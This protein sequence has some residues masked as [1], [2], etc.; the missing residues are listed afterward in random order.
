MKHVCKGLLLTLLVLVVALSLFACPK[1]DEP[2]PTPDPEPLP[3]ETVSI[4]FKNGDA[5]VATKTTEKNTALTAADIPAAPV[6]EGKTFLG[7]YIGDTKVEAGYIAA[8]D[9]TA[10]AKFEDTTYTLI[11]KNGDETVATITVKHGATPAEDALPSDPEKVGFSFDGWLAGDVAFDEEA[12]VTADATYT[13]AFTKTHYIVIFKNGDAET[14]VLVPLNAAALTAEMIP[15]VPAAP[16]GSGCDGWFADG[17][18]AESGLAIT[19]DTTF[20]AHFVGADA[21]AGVYADLVHGEFLTIT[22]ALAASGKA[23]GTAKLTPDGTLS[24]K[25]SGT[26]YTVSLTA[27][28]VTLTVNEYDAMEEEFVDTV[29]TMTRLSVVEGLAGTYKFARTTSYTV[30]E[31]GVVTAYDN[32]SS[33]PY[34]GLVTK[35]EDGTM[36]LLKKTSASGRLDALAITVDSKGNWVV[37]DNGYAKIYVKAEKDAEVKA[38]YCSA[39]GEYLYVIYL[40]KGSTDEKVVTYAKSAD[41]ISCYATIDGTIASNN[42]VTFTAGDK[43]ATVKLG[44]LSTSEMKFTYPGAEKDKS[45]TGTLGTIT[46]DGF[47]NTKVGAT[48]Y[49]YELRG[50]KLFIGGETHVLLLDEAGTYTVL[51]KDAYAGTYIIYTAYE[52]VSG[53]TVILDGYGTFTKKGKYSNTVGTYTVAAGK[54]I[55]TGTDYS[56]EWNVV[57]GGKA[58]TMTKYEK[59][60]DLVL[61][62]YSADISEAVSALLGNWEDASGNKIA[63]YWW[64]ADGCYAMDF[65]G[66]T[67]RLTPYWDGSALV[68]TGWK[69]ACAEFPNQTATLV[70]TRSGDNLIITHGCTKDDGDGYGETKTVTWTYTA[71]TEPFAFEEDVRG[72]WKDADG[73]YTLVIGEDTLTL[74]GKAAADITGSEGAY[75]FTVDGTAYTL[76]YYYDSKWHLAQGSDDVTLAKEIAIDP[77]VTE[78]PE[79][80]RGTWIAKVEDRRETSGYLTYKF[81]ITADGAAYAVIG[82]YPASQTY[83][84]TS[85]DVDGV[86]T[87]TC[88]D[89]EETFTFTLTLK[90]ETLHAYQ[91]SY[92]EFDMTKEVVETLDDFAGTWTN[93]SLSWTFDGKGKVT[94]EDGNTYDYT[95]ADGKATFANSTYTITVTFNEDGTANVHYDDGCGE[96]V[97]DKTF[98][99][100]AAE[101]PAET[102]D[103][104]VGTWETSGFAKLVI[105]GKGGYTLGDISG[106]YT[107]KGDVATAADPTIHN[108]DTDPLTFTLKDGKLIVNF[109]QDYEEYTKTLTK[110]A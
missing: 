109:W 89:G 46:L 71:Y 42:V 82:D 45:Y 64:E 105:D 20:T 26:T 61:N 108:F 55:V 101:E 83:T 47:G 86:V 63:I 77:S 72:T 51:T 54:I 99:K 73:N 16:D 7:W 25:V 10:T 103:A 27:N 37:N 94:N 100:Q 36:T 9:A 110:T 6:V 85:C 80:M 39:T 98:T 52:E 4:V 62:T 75:D 3:A 92:V 1:Q 95:V 12:A 43:T 76:Y 87:I 104:F 78:I 58:M 41:K 59:R 11:F 24:W 5:T 33:A 97:F 18:K 31:Y 68:Y 49:A 19:A 17:V 102:L 90:G 91:N 28:G 56:G 38:Y 29:Y 34:F 84:F 44:A 69:D 74:N 79:A 13:A 14:T 23:T 96:D 32:N 2:L 22:D 106:T 93:G 30:N 65:G 15:A 66:V 70:I 88:V 107:V 40:V 67:M 21:F 50:D 57:A 53:Y 8:A 60:Y 48:D 81:V 35:N